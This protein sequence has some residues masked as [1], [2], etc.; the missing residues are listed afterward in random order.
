M[1]KGILQL[2]AT[3]QVALQLEY[4]E[5]KPQLQM[6]DGDMGAECGE[7]SANRSSLTG[8]FELIYGEY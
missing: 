6:P 1:S 4:R 5:V 3:G 8:T 2:A 7:M